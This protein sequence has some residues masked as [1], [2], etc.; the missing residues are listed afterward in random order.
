MSVCP[1]ATQGLMSS[2]GWRNDAGSAQKCSVYT[3]AYEC[4]AGDKAA[5]CDDR[6]EYAGITENDFMMGDPTPEDWK[7]AYPDDTGY[8]GKFFNYMNQNFW[9]RTHEF[10]AILSGAQQNAVRYCLNELS[11]L[12]MIGTIPAESSGLWER[13][14]MISRNNAEDGG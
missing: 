2:D 14:G 1:D 7:A 10:S 5:A 3:A 9:Q 6:G 4:Y 13:L 11:A 12:G 8:Y